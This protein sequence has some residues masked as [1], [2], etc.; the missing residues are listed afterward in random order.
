MRSRNNVAREHRQTRC[1]IRVLPVEAGH[2]GDSRKARPRAED[3][4]EPLETRHK[5]IVDC[6]ANRQKKQIHLSNE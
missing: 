6:S 3:P 4:L 5:G 1:R 2:V